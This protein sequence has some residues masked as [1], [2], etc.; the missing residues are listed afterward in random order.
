MHYLIK[1][2]LINKRVHIKNILTL[3]ILT[4]LCFSQTEEWI[5]FN[6]MTDYEWGVGMDFSVS[7]IKPDGMGN[8][9]VLEDV[10]YSDLSEE[11]TK[12]LYIA[13]G[14]LHIY[15]T[16]TMESISSGNGIPNPTFASFTH[17]ENMILFSTV[18]QDTGIGS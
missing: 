9:I 5:Y 1:I 16:E 17:D 11:G 15:N 2:L 8:E 10:Q 18:A 12:L 13:D 14:N 6:Y 7:R 3:L 4:T